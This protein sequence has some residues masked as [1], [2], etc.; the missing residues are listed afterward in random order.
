[1]SYA[2][3]AEGWVV[4]PAARLG[5]GSGRSHRGAAARAMTA[6]RPASAGRPPGEPPFEELF[7]PHA[8]AIARLC[9]RMLGEGA[10][11]DAAQEV[12]LRARRGFG[13]YDAGRPFRPWL[14][15]VAGNHCIDELRRRSHEMCL[16]ETGDLE[17]G[18]LRDPGPS[19][20]SH[21]LAGE[22]RGELVDVLDELPLKQRLPLALRYFHEL[23]YAAIAEILGVSRNQVGVLL[24]RAKRRLRERLAEGGS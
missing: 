24:Y 13:S 21:A 8:T 10:A 11:E 20:L 17:V 3:V 22:R 4:L 7:R 12:F 6:E 19:P 2:W 14:L 23:D 18:D 9:R 15:A 16:F 1:M 5:S